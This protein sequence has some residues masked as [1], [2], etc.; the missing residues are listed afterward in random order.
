[1]ENLW[2]LIFLAIIFRSIWRIIQRGGQQGRT[3]EPWEYP[4]RRR[5]IPGR[6][7]PG[8]VNQD[9][10]KLNIPEYLKRRDGGTAGGGDAPVAVEK[11]QPPAREIPV[12]VATEPLPP[13]RETVFTRERPAAEERPEQPGREEYTPVLAFTEC[14]VEAMP[15]GADK[16]ATCRKGP[17]H[18]RRRF[19]P[20]EGAI[21]PEELYKG[22]VWSQVLGS[23]GGLQAQRRKKFPA[24]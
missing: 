21:C 6:G 18:R 8:P 13:A 15:P 7:R 9:R 22:I 16:E 3:G 20:L 17:G 1:M 10:P 19:G 5:E 2:V 23:R 14:P 4:P 12:P 24:S 11:P